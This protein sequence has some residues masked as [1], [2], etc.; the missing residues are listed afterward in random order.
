MS[1][2][3][4]YSPLTLILTLT[5]TLTLTLLLVT[6]G[7]TEARETT[8]VVVCQKVLKMREERAVHVYH[9]RLCHENINSL[10]KFLHSCRGW[11]HT[12]LSPS[13]S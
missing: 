10:C 13:H 4:P 3:S 7:P 2:G 6:V 11:G 1:S 9:R 12:H 5:L 8:A